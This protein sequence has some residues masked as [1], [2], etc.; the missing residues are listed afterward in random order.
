[1][2]EGGNHGC[3]LGAFGLRNALSYRSEYDGVLGKDGTLAAIS[4]FAEAATLAWG[5]DRI[6]PVL[7]W[8][9]QVE[10]WA[11]EVQKLGEKDFRTR[12]R[13]CELMGAPLAAPGWT[14]EDLGNYYGAGACASFLS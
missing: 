5:S 8:E 13:R 11:S 6:A 1:M 3:G 9:K 2:H 10:A 7:S 12:H 14:W 4:T